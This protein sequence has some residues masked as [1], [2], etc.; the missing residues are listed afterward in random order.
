M[1]PLPGYRLLEPLGSG[2]FGEVWKCEVPGGLC[3][4]IKFVPGSVL[5]DGDNSP[6]EQELD[7]LRRIKAIRHPFILSVE[8]VEIVG[9]ELVIVTELADRSLQDVLAEC[10]RQGQEG[11]RREL[12][13]AFLLEAAEALDVM[14]FQHGLQHLDIKP[15]NLFLVSDHVKVADFG[16]VNS[17]EEFH[18]GAA[19]RRKGVTPLYAAPEVLQG[20]MSRHSDQYS[21]ALAYQ[22]LLTGTLPF[23]GK[24]ARQMLLQR[25]TADPDLGPLPPGDR[26]VVARALARDADARFPSCLDFIQALV[27]VPEEQSAADPASAAAPRFP[28]GAATPG[29]TRALRLRKTSSVFSGKT[30]TPETGAPP[31]ETAPGPADGTADEIILGAAAQ[32]SEETALAGPPPA[33]AFAVLPGYK[34]LDLLSQGPLGEVWRVQGANGQPRLAHLLPVVGGGSPEAQGRLLDRLRGLRHP[35]LE[36]AELFLAPSG[37]VVVL[38]TVGTQTL[39]DRLQE[40][41][42]DRLPG[43]PRSELLGY[44]A[45][46]AEALDALHQSHGLP[47]LGLSPRNVRVE[48]GEATVAEFGILPLVWLPTGE[49]AGP[50]NPRYAAPELFRKGGGPAADQYSLA[51]IYAEML[52]GAHPRGKQLSTR[53]LTAAKSPRPDLALLSSRDQD[54]LARALDADPAQ[55]FP[56]CTDLVK[57]LEGATAVEQVSLSCAPVLPY[58]NLRGE[59]A[60]ADLVVPSTRELVTEL[61]SAV[62]GP[63]EVRPFGGSYYFLRPG[64]TLEHRCPVRFLPSAMR[65]KFNG[66]RDKWKAQVVS[67]DD[68]SFVYRL[69]T[70]RGFLQRC[71]SRASGLEVQI[72]IRPGGRPEDH[73]AE[74]RVHIRPFGV[75]NQAEATALLEKAPRVL[76]SLRSYLQVGTEQRGDDRWPCALPLE[77]WPVLPPG[78]AAGPTEGQAKDISVSGIGFVV[79]QPPPCEKVYLRVLTPGR[80]A[81][82]ALLARAVRVHPMAEGSYQVG[83]AFVTED[84]APAS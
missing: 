42:G 51:L 44:L 55:R 84:A 11:I 19:P 62:E 65:L 33:S 29:Q 6:A 8:R 71:L 53:S 4:A 47:H 17:P 16:L 72:G 69:N 25:L 75:A 32:G 9:G 50:L 23:P 81:D 67:E 80:P 10:R 70:R 73:L 22:E 66:F 64:P 3:K 59:P 36:P 74:A 77:M 34:F 5:L 79:P 58:A 68:A 46:V 60:P 48:G 31:G 52:T 26:P 54:I 35:V 83:A 27:A 2:G 61:I 38:T 21:L 49:P 45:A 20:G 37:R 1:E 30:L 40:C 56:S 43:I 15:G 57:A 14:N 39:R 76:A 78:E 82:F 28:P 12:L 13:L 18:A 63:I 24:N 41:L 7:A